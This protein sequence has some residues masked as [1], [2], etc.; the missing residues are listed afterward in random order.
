MKKT[1]G[2]IMVALGCLV[3]IGMVAGFPRTILYISSLTEEQG[4]TAYAIGY[5]G[6]QILAMVVAYLLITYG[7]RLS[8]SK[9]ESTK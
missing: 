6:G 4:W 9:E 2:V 8:K 5:V 3:A 7:L 1:L